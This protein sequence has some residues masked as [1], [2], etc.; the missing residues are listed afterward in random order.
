MTEVPGT[1]SLILKGF[2]LATLTRF[3][4][5]KQHLGFD[6]YRMKARR[7]SNDRF[8]Y[9]KWR[10]MYRIA[11]AKVAFPSTSLMKRERADIITAAIWG[12]TVHDELN[13][14]QNIGMAYRRSVTA[15]LLPGPDS[16]LNT[17]ETEQGFPAYTAWRQSGFPNPVPTGV[18][19]EHDYYVTQVLSNREFF[20][21]DGG[22]TS[23]MGITM[24]VPR[25]GDC[26]CVLL[27]GDTPF[28][29]RPKGD[30]WHFV[31][32]AYVHGIM[33]GEAMSRTREPGLEY[34][35]FVIT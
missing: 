5:V 2:L 22:K 11:A 30:E 14:E 32:E 25:D 28:V 23:Y 31:A 33:D 9:S 1:K 24:G 7:F 21:A 29:M 19:H 17:R 20:I 13:D 6:I 8:Q 16:S 10:E 12:K 18:L 27:D 26:V 35:T 4:N 34:T 3:A 15:D